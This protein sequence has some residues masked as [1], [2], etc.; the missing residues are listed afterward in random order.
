MIFESPLFAFFFWDR[1]SGMVLG[2]DAKNSR[3]HME[4]VLEV[5]VLTTNSRELLKIKKNRCLAKNF[6]V[7]RKNMCLSEFFRTPSFLN[8]FPLEIPPRTVYLIFDGLADRF[9]CCLFVCV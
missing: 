1:L 7:S 2:F 5:L 9:C 3:M 6:D 4:R 8:V